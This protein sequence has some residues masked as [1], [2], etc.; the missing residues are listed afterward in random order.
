MRK[1]LAGTPRGSVATL[2]N[3]KCYPQVKKAAAKL[4]Y[5]C[6]HAE[7]NGKLYVKIMDTGSDK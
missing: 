7:Q 6:H 5:E 2:E 3:T 4:G 1:A